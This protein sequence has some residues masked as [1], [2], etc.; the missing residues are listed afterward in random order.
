[1]ENDERRDKQIQKT[2]KCLLNGYFLQ[3]KKPLVRTV[4]IPKDMIFKKF[5][6]NNRLWIYINY[7]RL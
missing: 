6:P 3:L 7:G 1:M 2:D 5:E 4:S